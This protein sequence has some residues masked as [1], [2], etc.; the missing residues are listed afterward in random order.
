MI[1]RNNISWYH[2]D[3]PQNQVI[4]PYQAQQAD[5]LT[6]IEG[7]IIHVLRKLP[8]GEFFH[9]EKKFN[10]EFFSLPRKVKCES[11]SRYSVRISD[12]ANFE[13]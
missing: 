5:E 2:L 11:W 10:S 13:D 4:Y 3:C 9:W 12:T 1:L 6:L 7:D 8:D